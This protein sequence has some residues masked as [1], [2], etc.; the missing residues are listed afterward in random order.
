V[1]N[2]QSYPS[3]RAIQVLRAQQIEFTPRCYRYIGERNVAQEAAAS[4]GVPDSEVFK[5]LVFGGG[6]SPVLVLIDAA[7]RVGQ[8][9]LST[10]IGSSYR[11]SECSACVAERYT[12]YKVGGIS[13][14][15]TRR[16]MPVYLDSAVTAIERVYV[17]GGSRGFMLLIRVADLIK[18]L[19]PIIADLRSE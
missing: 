15:G 14:F 9:K 8:H 2:K 6:P 16:S 17:N 19:K 11:V 4:L 7:H 18:V 3:T 13:P 5:T 12:G 10:V 1:S